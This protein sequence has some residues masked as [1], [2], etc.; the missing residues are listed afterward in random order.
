LRKKQ[1]KNSRSTPRAY[2][3]TPTIGNKE[4]EPV[5]VK[6][7]HNGEPTK[8]QPGANNFQGPFRSE[9]MAT[10]DDDLDMKLE[11]ASPT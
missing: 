3:P 2:H 9:D 11:K 8:S 10:N 7:L 4:W 6:R 1:N 5:A